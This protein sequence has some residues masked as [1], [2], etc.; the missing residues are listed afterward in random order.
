MDTEPA[1]AFPPKGALRR[2]AFPKLVREIARGKVTG[3][4]YLLSGQTK[5][6]VFFEE[7]QPVFVRSNVLSE[8]LGQVLSSE[9]L[10]TQEQCEQTL[11]A[12]RRTGKKQGELLVEMGI[13]SEGNLRYG[14]AAQLRTKLYDI[15]AWDD[16]RYQF[17]SDTATNGSGVRLDARPE[18]VIIGAILDR[19]NESRAEKLLESSMGEYLVYG[20]DAPLDV[21]ELD[22]LGEERYFVEC[23]DGSRTVAQCVRDEL[24]QGVPNP[25]ALVYGLVQA[26]V[27]DLSSTSLESRPRPAKPNFDARPDDETLTP[28]FDP[29]NVITEYEDTPLPGELPQMRALLGDHEDD[30]ADVEALETST[31][32]GPLPADLG[33]PSAVT[34]QP[35]QGSQIS[36]DLIA[37]EPDQVEETFDDSELQEEVS[38]ASLAEPP[39]DEG[40]VDEAGS[41]PA[42]AQTA[43]EDDDDGLVDPLEGLDLDDLDDLEMEPEP[44]P[45]PEPV[46]PEALVEPE[47][48]LEPEIDID[49][50]LELEPDLEPDLNLDPDIDIEPEL[51]PEPEPELE[52]EPEPEPPV[53]DAEP[54]PEPPPELTAEPEAPAPAVDDSDE[55]L[56]LDELDELEEPELGEPESAEAEPTEPPLMDLADEDPGATR[57]DPLPP[58]AVNRD[59]A[60]PR[61]L[62]PEPEPELELEPDLE[63]DFGPALDPAAQLGAGSDDGA[64]AEDFDVDDDLLLAETDDGLDDLL[65]V[66]DLGELDDIDLGEA[67]ALEVD[68]DLAFDDLDPDGALDEPAAD[69]DNLVDLD[70]LDDVELS[71]SG[72]ASSPSSG[73]TGGYSGPEATFQDSQDPEMVGAMHFNDAETALAERRFPDAVALLESA[74]DN[75]FDVAELHA[76]LAFARFMAAGQDLET[77][78]H[79]FE[80]LEYSESMD[81]SLDLVWAYRGSLHQ[82][83]GDTDQAR[84]ALGRALELNPY[85]ELA[86]Q[87]MDELG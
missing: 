34:P 26:G 1:L 22:L 16:G 84:S 23:I 35:S 53:L 45:Q 65:P 25:H 33:T 67:D 39:P 66:D 2:F 54:A 82:S 70:D 21:A 44:D 72:P 75:G 31:S 83:L 3:S 42:A 77:A 30:F 28:G 61:P 24:A 57:A 8:C 17:K 69:D 27:A 5:K 63:A 73:P 51:E 60:T 7:G 59:L 38:G 43:P 18:A 62:D 58:M 4:L 87:L 50:E 6:V 11:E 10:I 13:L 80:L 78:Q 56:E 14:L 19:Y 32:V 48:P 20:E 36:E 79:A 64:S 71:A 68:D 85:C 29:H 55:I 86:I 76:M 52:L 47:P 46:Q 81:P 49:T 74:Y 41:T 40:D 12:I 9:G 15:F 37:A